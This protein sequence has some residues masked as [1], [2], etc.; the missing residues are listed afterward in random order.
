[1]KKTV[2]ILIA[3]LSGLAM[4]LSF[5]TNPTKTVLGGLEP[6]LLAWVTPPLYPANPPSKPYCAIKAAR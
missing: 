6:N 5:F 3:F 1:M 2:P 4:V